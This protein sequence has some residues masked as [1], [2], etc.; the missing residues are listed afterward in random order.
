MTQEQ[1]VMAG[2]VS[3][4]VWKLTR[5]RFP[6]FTDERAEFVKDYDA[7]FPDGT[8]TSDQKENEIT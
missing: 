7:A 3:E 4:S 6:L 8:L 2:S 1:K 5:H